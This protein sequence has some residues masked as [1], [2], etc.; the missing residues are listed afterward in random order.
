VLNGD[1]PAL[2]NLPGFENLI[3]GFNAITNE[4]TTP[5]AEFVIASK[6][7][8]DGEDQSAMEHLKKEDFFTDTITAPGTAREQDCHGNMPGIQ[9]GY[10]LFDSYNIPNEVLVR[11]NAV[12]DGS[13]SH[14]F[15]KNS[16][17]F[18]EFKARSLGINV[19]SDL[20]GGAFQLDTKRSSITKQ[21][22]SMDMMLTEKD[23][24]LY[25]LAPNSRFVSTE[26]PLDPQEERAIEA[27]TTTK[28][29]RTN[30]RR[31]AITPPS[32][33]AKKGPCAVFGSM[34]FPC[35]NSG[36]LAQCKDA[37]G[38]NDE[39]ES[40]AGSDICNEPWM[41]DAKE[42]FKDLIPRLGAIDVGLDSIY[43]KTIQED[44]PVYKFFANS[45][46]V[47]I[48]LSPDESTPKSWIVKVKYTTLFL[49]CAKTLKTCTACECIAKDGTM[50]K[51]AQNMRDG[52][53]DQAR[54]AFA[55][56][57]AC[58]DE[59]VCDP[60]GLSKAYGVTQTCEPAAS[61]AGGYK[62]TCLSR[63][64]ADKVEESEGAPVDL[65]TCKQQHRGLSSG[66]NS[67]GLHRC[68]LV[69]DHHVLEADF[70]DA[71]H[72]DLEP[73]AVLPLKQARGPAMY[74]ALDKL[75]KQVE[76]AGGAAPKYRD[77]TNVAWCVPYLIGHLDKAE[78]AIIAVRKEA[79]EKAQRDHTALM[80]RGG[81]QPT[82]A[83]NDF[84]EEAMLLPID[85]HEVLKC[86]PA[87]MLD[88]ENSQ[89]L[90]AD[91]P[92][93]ESMWDVPILANTPDVIAMAGKHVANGKITLKT[94]FRDYGVSFA[95]TGILVRIRTGLKFEDFM[96]LPS[97]ITAPEYT[98][99]A[100]AYRKF[101]WT[102][103]THYV[104]EVTMGG[105]M[106]SK[107]FLKKSEHYSRT[108]AM[109]KADV[110]FDLHADGKESETPIAVKVVSGVISALGLASP[111]AAAAKSVLPTGRI[112]MSHSRETR[113]ENT[114]QQSSE[115]LE[116]H[117]EGGDPALGMSGDV[118]G[119]LDSI[120]ANPAV[121]KRTM[122]PISNLLRPNARPTCKGKC[123]EDILRNGNSCSGMCLLKGNCAADFSR[124]CPAEYS[125]AN[126]E[127]VNQLCMTASDNV[128]ESCN[129]KFHGEGCHCHGGEC[130]EPAAYVCLMENNVKSGADL[131]RCQCKPK[132]S[133]GLSKSHSMPLP[134][135]AASPNFRSTG[136]SL[137][138][139]RSLGLHINSLDV[140]KGALRASSNIALERIALERGLDMILMETGLMETGKSQPQ[141]QVTA[142][143][144][145]VS[146]TTKPTLS[147]AS[148][149]YMY[150]KRH[151]AQV[152]SDLM[153]R[154]A[155]YL[156]AQIKYL[157]HTVVQMENTKATNAPPTEAHQM[158]L[159][160]QQET[161]KYRKT[162]SQMT[163]LPLLFCEVKEFN[164]IPGIGVKQMMEAAHA[165]M[166]QD[167]SEDTKE[168]DAEQLLIDSNILL[169][170]AVQVETKA[171]EI[172]A[173]VPSSGSAAVSC[174]YRMPTASD[175]AD[176][177]KLELFFDSQKDFKLDGKKG[178][179][180]QEKKKAFID[181]F[182]SDPEGLFIKFPEARDVEYRC[183]WEK[184][185]M[186]SSDKC[187]GSMCANC[188]TVQLSLDNTQPMQQKA[189]TECTAEE[190]SVSSLGDE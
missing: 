29:K 153:F 138:P 40:R 58:S 39:W 31:G 135:S 142:K 16:G 187:C 66:A 162:W 36:V 18:Y 118:N 156:A 28:G 62:C 96:K 171:C 174:R 155:N 6:F 137:L 166:I 27:G 4:R 22:S 165:N 121:V 128:D 177:S 25:D 77:L 150:D 106:E 169:A 55:D 179:K 37:T 93:M 21:M 43:E 51:L 185:G 141:Q 182:Y 70:V 189:I 35:Q 49:N 52:T 79:Y 159:I 115:G 123:G 84:A 65:K 103:G 95:S 90:A 146:P 64:T 124:R 133:H 88:P 167:V 1:L 82:S 67:L 107:V 154:I 5:L 113:A 131:S 14:K 89:Y 63:D 7:E 108:A 71:M 112:S 57:C 59:T 173:S 172:L 114:K 26:C 54:T 143:M 160:V 56:H 12:G 181:L 17:E 38:C 164:C 105:K 94:I 33:A 120:M 117:F 186:I 126:H 134:N 45:G 11:C 104:G 68:M 73:V 129:G 15:F 92:T 44:K 85:A 100:A 99:K 24:T 42:H 119:W 41:E 190:L 76:I 180:G 72:M 144:T 50:F 20:F 116:M 97:Y 127:L 184:T 19:G 48:T 74:T 163:G 10:G 139:D 149:D 176:K 170:R 78:K 47:D 23:L 152:Q 136:A 148:S 178:K 98:T 183:V 158:C 87:E 83:E 75:P 34:D 125:D 175:M 140:N 168:K 130:E 145:P 2:N 80:H 86:I 132:P 32:E 188:G 157:E 8:L 101:I 3:T 111:T 147:T 61:V 122:I 9:A 91:Y 13:S 30:V 53:V 60:N 46:G 151:F 109:T 110:S 69:V 102:F 161:N 81:Q